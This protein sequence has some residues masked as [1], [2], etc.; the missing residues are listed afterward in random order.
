MSSSKS[1]SRKGRTKTSSSKSSGSKTKASGSP[2]AGSGRSGSSRSKTSAS[3]TGAR[4]SASRSKTGSSRSSRSGGKRSSAKS[5]SENGVVG[6]VK[7]AASKASG[8]ALAVGAAAAGVAGGL[9]L[10][11]RARRNKVL[12]VTVPRSIG[13]PSLPDFDAK[14]MAKTVSKASKQFGQTS[15]TVSKH[16]ER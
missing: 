4:S 10:K 2:R 8:P 16:I 6:T 3:S 11:N 5:H 12:G 7:H 13:K 9:A 15:K 14:S 1:A